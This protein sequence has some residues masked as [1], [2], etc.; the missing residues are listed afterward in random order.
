VQSS[1][2]TATMR[3]AALRFAVATTLLVLALGLIV[4]PDPHDE[5]R[6]A[7]RLFQQRSY[8]AA[9]QIYARLSANPT[10]AEAALS[11]GALR[12]VRGEY[13]LAERAMRQAMA[14][15]LTPEQYDLAM[16][17]VGQALASRG[18]AETAARTWGLLEPCGPQELCSYRSPQ[19]LL[20]AEQAL[21][22]EDYAAAEAG[23]RQALTGPLPSDWYDLA[24][25]RLALLGAARDQAA[26]LV[27]LSQLQAQRPASAPSAALLE[28]LLP[29]PAISIGQL[30]AV[31]QDEP[32]SRAQALGQLYLDLGL[33]SLAEA[34]FAKVDSQ[35]PEALTARTYAAYTRWL[36][37]DRRGGLERLEQLVEAYPSEARARTL[38]ALAYTA[39][40]QS[41]A[42]RAQID[43]ISKI[44]PASPETRLAWAGWYAAQR[45]YLR[46]AEEYQLAIAQAPAA[47]KGRYALLGANFHLVTTYDLCTA[48]LSMA[49]LAAQALNQNAAAQTSLAAHR[50]RCG[51]L[52]GAEA[53]AR[54]ALA[55]SPAAAD[56]TYY[57][58]AALAGLGDTAQARS[59]LVRAADLAPASLW[60]SRAEEALAKLP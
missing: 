33:Y 50:Y 38:L 19:R 48:G 30:S 21:K 40:D 10:D 43:A 35:G 57:L 49:E 25:L 59:E 5:H 27:E 29:R 53:A 51:D 23:Y 12:M 54:G 16:L 36:A 24:V 20:Q 1:R 32:A 13:E 14:R 2:I 41:E 39:E 26:A 37:G 7:S 52:A 18:L 55:L 31:L 56:A 11:L 17:Y 46:A 47:D 8:Y 44:R 22:R 15:G 3:I 34:Q 58:G 28:P 42:A 60:R 4:R 6:A 9:L 45:D